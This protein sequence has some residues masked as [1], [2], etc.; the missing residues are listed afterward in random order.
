MGET[1]T[2]AA[3]ATTVTPT[4][5][6]PTTSTSTTL[7]PTTTTA[8]ATTTT[9]LIGST[10]PLRFDG[11]G[12][13]RFGAD[14]DDVITYISDIIGDPTAD[15]DWINARSVGCLGEEARTVSWDDLHLTFG[16][17]SNVST[18]RRHFYAWIYGPPSGSAIAPAGM[19]TPLGISVSSSVAAIQAA[20]PG[21]QLIAGDAQ[22]T[23]SAQLSAGLFAYLTDARQTG[24][25]TVLE[26]GQVCVGFPGGD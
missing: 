12:D 6:A 22:V 19:A 4:T 7:A 18:G 14:P 15:T 20:Y 8:A 25:V 10:I 3:S 9:V 16:D 17:E 11:I 13:A 21:A 23:P 1:T 26:G 5:V 24:V 2:S